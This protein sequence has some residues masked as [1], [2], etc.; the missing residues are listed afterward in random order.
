MSICIGVFCTA[1]AFRIKFRNGCSDQ[2]CACVCV[3]ASVCV[4]VFLCMCVCV[5]VCLGVSMYTILC[6]DDT[7]FVKIIGLC[8]N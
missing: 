5:S 8:E 7:V 3:C 6:A 4:C 1:D 2:V